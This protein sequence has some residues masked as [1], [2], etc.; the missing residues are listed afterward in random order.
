MRETS[1]LLCF[2]NPGQEERRR[3]AI[4][5]ISHDQ[6]TAIVKPSDLGGAHIRRKSYLGSSSPLGGSIVAYPTAI[7]LITGRLVGAAL[8][9]CRKGK[10]TPT[11]YRFLA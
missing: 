2:N 11:S 4:Y 6:L 7:R 10:G 5:T 1:P 8:A 9:A 3:L